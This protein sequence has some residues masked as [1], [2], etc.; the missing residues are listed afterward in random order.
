[1]KQTKIPDYILVRSGTFY[2]RMSVPI[3]LRHALGK[4]ELKRSLNTKS[5]TEAALRAP[6]AIASFQKQ[7]VEAAARCTPVHTTITEVPFEDARQFAK[8]RLERM[9]ALPDQSRSRGRQFLNGSSTDRARRLAEN[10]SLL[11]FFEEVERSGQWD[12]WRNALG[13]STVSAYEQE[14][15]VQVASQSI[16]QGLLSELGAEV[17]V[18]HLR[19]AIY[20]D[21][22]RHSTAPA[23]NSSTALDAEGVGLSMAKLLAKYRVAKEPI[24]KPSSA[25]A[26]VKVERLLHDWFGQGRSIST[27]TRDDWRELFNAL[28]KIPTGYTRMKTFRGLTVKQVIETADRMSEPPLRLSAKTCADYVIHVN[29]LLNWAAKEALIPQN[30]AKDLTPPRFAR[31]ESP[32]RPFETA[33]LQCLFSAGLFEGH[34][35]NRVADGLY[36]LPLVALFTG[37]RSGEIARL[38]VHDI[39]EV[40]GVSCIRLTDAG[41][42]KTSNAVRDI[43]VHSELQR[44][45]FLDFTATQFEAGHR[46]LFPEIRRNG[47]DDQSSEFAKA[48][49]KMLNEAG[50]KDRTLSMHS[51]R[52]SFAHALVTLQTTGA[53]ADALMG[54]GEKKP[55]NMFVHY[56]GR[57]PIQQL[58]AVVAQV[59]YPGLD[60]RHLH[61]CT[62]TTET[63]ARRRQFD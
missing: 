18:E 37:M 34:R 29:S 39:A 56:G 62:T 21:E 26:F 40:R 48:F 27:I 47:K 23:P 49:R 12:G 43:P 19:R 17:A 33:E 7:L 61:R 55:R 4:T 16:A 13:H 63:S 36:W 28:P 20:R 11:A 51:F 22:N 53:V 35:P 32:R 54:W 58:A 25:I 14:R 10:K 38:K 42:L 1:M 59:T 44:L 50:L 57:P 24:W 8:E 15:H 9:Q 45:G 3:Q 6:L 31:V 5:R 46:D 41:A 30:Q 52:H 2:V 60:L